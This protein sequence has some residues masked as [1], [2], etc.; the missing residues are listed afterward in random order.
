MRPYDVREVALWLYKQN[1]RVVNNY[2]QRV[3]D[4][5]TEWESDKAQARKKRKLM[6]VAIYMK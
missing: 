5:A 6:M 1:A 3:E 4:N 2:K